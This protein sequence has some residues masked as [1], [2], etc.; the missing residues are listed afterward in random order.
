MR[1]RVAHFGG[2]FR[3]TSRVGTGTRIYVSVPSEPSVVEPVAAAL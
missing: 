2:V 3:V 1:E